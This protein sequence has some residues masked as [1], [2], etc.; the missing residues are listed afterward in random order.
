MG[1][2]RHAIFS[3]A[4]GRTYGTAATFLFCSEMAE[5]SKVTEAR[6][7]AETGIMD[8]PDQPYQPT[9]WKFPVRS[10]GNTKPVRRTFQAS[11][12]QKFKWLHYDAAKDAAFCFSCCSTVKSGKLKLKGTTENAFLISGFTNWKDATR[13]MNK[14]EN[15]NFHRH[16]NEIL[17]TTTDVS[18][19]L[20][21]QTVTEREKNRECFILI[22]KSLRHL[23]RQGLP[24]RGSGDESNSNFI[25][26][27]KLICGHSL[28]LSTFL[29]KKQLK[30]TS[31][32]I[33]NELLSIMAQHIL[34]QIFRNL[35]SSY[36]AI[37]ADEVTDVSNCEQVAIVI[38]WVDDSLMPHEEYIGLYKTESI[39]S[40]S[41]VS[42]IK[43]VLLRLGLPI[44]K[45]RGQ[46]YDGASSMS[47]KLELYIHTAMVM[48]SIWLSEM[49]LNSVN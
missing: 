18:E 8:V 30:F 28:H 15:C 7:T 47:M 10:F 41:L 31:H 22:A 34:R 48:L 27:L 36:N 13:A 26:L 38:H 25:Q 32:E 20:S 12:F 42:L 39:T 1:G 6:V 46:C 40:Q 45:C 2:L 44:N 16:A 24:L 33:Q 35:Q 11:W 21:K 5:C 9:D 29:T 4:R 43:D 19:M 49:L 3:L 37:M 23:A 17:A 14:H